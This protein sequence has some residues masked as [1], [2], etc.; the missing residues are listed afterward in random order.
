MSNTSNTEMLRWPHFHPFQD[1][2]IISSKLTSMQSSLAMLVDTPDYSEKCVHL[3]ALKNRLEAL[4]SPQIVSTF[5]SMSTGKS[6]VLTCC[7][8]FEYQAQLH[9]YLLLD[10]SSQAF[11]QDIHRD[12]QNAAAPCLLLQVSQGRF[13]F[14]QFNFMHPLGSNNITVAFV[15]HYEGTQPRM[16]VCVCL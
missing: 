2:A 13:H 9:L 10:R 1:L 7:S 5:N 11:R 16:N 8:F 4:A 6:A 3:E 12:W 15:I 14:S